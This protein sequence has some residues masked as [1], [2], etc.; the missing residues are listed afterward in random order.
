MGNDTLD[1]ADR[2]VLAAIGGGRVSEGTI[3]SRLDPPPDDLAD[4]LALLR[5]N[6]LVRPAGADKWELTENGVRALNAP[7]TGG[8]DERIDT[9]SEA[10]AAIESLEL[11]PGER[12]AVRNAFSYLRYWGDATSAEIVDGVYSE[13]PA[14]YEDAD[15]WWRDCVGRRLA[16]LP[17]V[18]GAADAGP[19]AW[20]EYGGPAAVERSAGRDGRAV[21]DDAASARSGSVRHGLEEAATDDEERRAARAAFAVLYDRGSAT[22]AALVEAANHLEN[23]EAT[24]DPGVEHGAPDGSLVVEHPSGFESG[25]AWAARLTELFAVVPGIERE[26]HSES[27]DE[28]VW[29]YRPEPDAEVPT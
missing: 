6:A 27:A 23:D 2:A 9:P 10:E 26:S 20:W 28:V 19:A 4:R 5:E 24:V 18:E 14:G 7:G 3:E 25:D 29:S 16:A 12:N 17:S 22:S 21:L 8:V 15:R 1:A 13:A 11:S